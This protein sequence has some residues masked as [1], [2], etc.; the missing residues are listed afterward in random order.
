MSMIDLVGLAH[1]SISY[2][3]QPSFKDM[4]WVDIRRQDVHTM[5]V[6]ATARAGV[7][8]TLSVLVTPKTSNVP[9]TG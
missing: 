5:E 8:D 6:E 2:W 1:D 3:S 7:R 9:M 4:M